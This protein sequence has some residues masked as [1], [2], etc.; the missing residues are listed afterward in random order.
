MAVVAVVVVVVVIVLVVI[1]V[2]VV[3]VV[4]VVLRVTGRQRRVQTFKHD[5]Q[6]RH[7]IIVR[8]NGRVCGT[9][10]Q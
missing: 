6:R 3:V 8:E 9:S 4:V 2:I 10:Y 7:G 5:K 1:V